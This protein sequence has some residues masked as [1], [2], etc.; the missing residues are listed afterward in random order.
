M[1]FWLLTNVA[2]D[3]ATTLDN[4]G[5]SITATGYTLTDVI[6]GP[7]STRW[8]SGAIAATLAISYHF[9]PTGG[10]DVEATHVVIAR[11]D[12]LVTLGTARVRIQQRSS[13]GTWSNLITL[14]PFTS[15]SLV[16]IV[17]TGKTHGQ[18]YVAAIT[19]TQKRGYG[20][21]FLS[22]SS[23]EA[24]QVSKV[25]FCN[26]VN[27][28]DPLPGIQWSV[29][30]E[31]IRPQRSTIPYRCERRLAIQWTDLRDTQV[32]LLTHAR[33]D[34]DGGIPGR[35]RQPL[36]WPMFLYD[37]AG[38]IWDWKLEHVLLES[39]QLTQIGKD[40]WTLAMTFVRLMHYD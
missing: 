1:S 26:G 23:N 17:K 14:D 15:S 25:Y 22:W 2:G 4:K 39:Y 40:C 38:N 5:A 6:S 27:L 32:A 37:D 34:G 9:D 10:G 16:G 21:D 33:T 31:Y 18:D 35:L 8:R 11:A 20:I 29:I 19:P 28:G 13:G 36:N 24:F 12:W 30:D 3:E 7:R